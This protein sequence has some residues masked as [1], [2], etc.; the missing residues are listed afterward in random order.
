MIGR[1]LNKPVD[2]T[3]ISIIQCKTLSE[4][5]EIGSFEYKRQDFEDKTSTNTKKEN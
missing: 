4:Q 5:K 3:P 1:I 2:I